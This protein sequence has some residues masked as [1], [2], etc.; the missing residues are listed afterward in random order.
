MSAPS[1]WS[2]FVMSATMDHFKDDV[3]S[4][5]HQE[6]VMLTIAP[7]APEQRRM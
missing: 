3:L 1:H 4:V 7:I 6:S 2:G 5:D